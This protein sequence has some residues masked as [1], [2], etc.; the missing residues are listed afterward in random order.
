MGSKMSKNKMSELLNRFEISS[1]INKEIKQI[2]RKFHV[3]DDDEKY[4]I[5]LITEEDEVFLFGSI[6]FSGFGSGHKI[7]FNEPQIIPELCHKNIQ[8]F[9]IGYKFIF[10]LDSD[11]QLYGWGSNEFGQLARGHISRENE[12]LR[13]E[14]VYLSNEKVIQVSCGNAHSLALTHEGNVYGW[15]NNSHGEVGCDGLNNIIKIP[16]KLQC[17]HEFPIKTI[18][19]SYMRSF[20]L[21][22]NGLVYSW[23]YNHWCELGHDLDINGIIFEPKLIIDITNVIY[24]CPSSVKTFF[25]TNDN[26]LY[27]CGY[28]KDEN[29]CESFQKTPKLLNTGLKFSSLH[30]IPYHQDKKSIAS[31]IS[32]N[33]IYELKWYEIERQDNSSFFDFYST[34]YNLTHKTIH[35]NS[36]HCFDVDHFEDFSLPTRENYLAVNFEIK[37]ERGSGGYGTVFEVSS[38]K[39][40]KIYAIKTINI[41][42]NM[43]ERILY[44]FSYTL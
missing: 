22:T 2:V 44:S 23:G 17:F 37:R 7:A 12:Y 32:G 11:K 1:K 33:T 28:F 15:G 35:L 9:F 41:K 4:N 21:T 18:L 38:K 3:F 29:N 16:I 42:G 40:H 24:I 19:C 43:L 27:F 14:I 26:D 36:D 8:Q 13:P 34:K 20:A 30:S 25:L 39:Y 5:L 31:A 6:F 10:S